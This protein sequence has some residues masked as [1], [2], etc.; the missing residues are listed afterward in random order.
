MNDT[1]WLRKAF[2]VPRR[3]GCLLLLG[4]LAVATGL[5]LALSA[6]AG[7]AAGPALTE[8]SRSSP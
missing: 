1:D 3:S 5:G 7:A 6:R 8:G 2:R 4:A